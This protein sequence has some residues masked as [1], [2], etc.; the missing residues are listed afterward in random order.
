M[1]RK[2]FWDL[3][4]LNR[5]W[6]LERSAQGD[7]V[8]MPPTGALT[9]KRN[10]ALLAQ[11]FA[12]AERDGSGVAFDSSTGFELPNGAVRSPDVAWVARARL[13][14]VPQNHL[15]RFLPLCPDFVIELRLPSDQLPPLQAKMEEYL[16]NGCRLGWLVDPVALR[17]HVYRADGPVETLD[18]P[19]VILGDPALPGLRVELDSIWPG[20]L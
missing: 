5:D 7:I 12:W 15:D 3:C 18:N 1:T 16:A 17:I 2:Q 19:A 11:V 9:G 14:G 8:A 6:R 10:A 13:A 4:Q 20:S